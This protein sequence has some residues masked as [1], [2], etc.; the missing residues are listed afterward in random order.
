MRFA[1]GKMFS[2]GKD[3]KVNVID[4]HNRTVERTVDFGRGNIIRSIDCNDSGALLVGQRNGTITCVNGED[5]SDIMVSHSDGEVWGL[6]ITPD[7]KVITSAD[8]N[9]VLCYKPDERKNV[10][11]VKVTDRKSKARKGGASTMSKY[12]DSQCSRAVAVNDTYLAVSGNDGAVS[13]R[14]V[15]SPDDE[16]G[17][18]QDAKEWNEV[19][20]FSP[21]NQY[22]AVG[23]HD[24]NIYVYSTADWS[25]VGKCSAHNS[26]IMAL[27]WCAQSKYIRSNCGAY[28][29]LFHTVPDCA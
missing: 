18:L 8:D 22:L 9:K 25:L 7:G 12:P 19:M 1:A 28:E 14:L 10:R 13:I 15:A 11:K 4:Y 21:D 2:G 5:R 29:L 17:L 20:A 26:Y 27:D 16:V 23:S 24:N 3:G 6:A